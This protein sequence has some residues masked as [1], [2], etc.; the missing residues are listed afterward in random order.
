[1]SEKKLTSLKLDPELFDE[2]KIECIRTK[3]TLQKLA[4]RSVYLFLKDKE[5]QKLILNTEVNFDEV[6]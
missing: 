2:F 3:F 1:M 6:K 5:F 4:E